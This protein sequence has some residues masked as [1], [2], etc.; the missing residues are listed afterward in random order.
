VSSRDKDIFA[1]I[2]EMAVPAGG[3]VVILAEAYVDESGTHDGSPMLA[4]G[5]YMFKREQAARFSRDWKKILD[6]YGLTA[7]HMTD[8]V[9]CAQD[10][11]RAGMTLAECDQCNRRLIENT[12]RR[13]MF[14]FGVSVDPLRYAEIVGTANNAPSAYTFCLMGCMTI[15]RRWIERTAF[16]GYVAYVFESGH[17][18]QQ[19]AH[20]F[21]SDALLYTESAKEKHRYASHNFI[22]KKLAL[23]LQAADML[24]W[25]YYH[26]HF[27]KV[28]MGIETPRKDFTA[29]IRDQD[30]C[31][32]HN[33][34]SLLRFRNEIVEPGWF[35]GRY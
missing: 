7:A 1:Q 23:P 15:I 34:E 5:G 33:D 2:V 30:V 13:T 10:Y 31:I 27:R 24:A 16:D 9:H 20:R 22:D 14:G 32:E 12:K 4:I 6:Q 8:A 35:I 25:H 26:Y 28:T 19:E 17:D 11:K 21:I 3:C 18:R 29:L